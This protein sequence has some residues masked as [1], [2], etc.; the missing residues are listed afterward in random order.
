MKLKMKKSEENQWSAAE[1][2]G[3]HLKEKT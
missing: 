2:A 1:M 3:P